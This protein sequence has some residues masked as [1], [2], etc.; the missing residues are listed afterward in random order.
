VVETAITEVTTLL[1]LYGQSV[2]YGAQL[3]MV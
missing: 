1:L 3:E 2:T